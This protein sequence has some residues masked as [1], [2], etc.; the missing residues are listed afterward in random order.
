[1]TDHRVRAFVYAVV[2]AVLSQRQAKEGSDQICLAVN[3]PSK[4]ISYLTL[5]KKDMR[6]IGKLER[7]ILFYFISIKVDHL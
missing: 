3:I 4:G 1:M 5:M 2:L 6:Y 7:L